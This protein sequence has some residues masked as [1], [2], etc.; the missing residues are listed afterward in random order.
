MEAPPPSTPITPVAP[1]GPP[2]GKLTVKVLQARN[3]KVN[4]PDVLIPIYSNAY[5]RLRHTVS[6]CLRIQSSSPE[7]LS[8]R[9][10][11]RPAPQRHLKELLFR[12]PDKVPPQIYRPWESW[13]AQ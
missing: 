5:A 1:I 9:I 3:L 11:R 10:Q 2:R 7:A 4:R 13:P 8:L 12:D 6:V